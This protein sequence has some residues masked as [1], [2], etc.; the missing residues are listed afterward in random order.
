[1]KGVT[2]AFTLT[3]P[4]GRMQSFGSRLEADAARVRAGGGTVS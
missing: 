3:T 4:A 1:M 2:Q